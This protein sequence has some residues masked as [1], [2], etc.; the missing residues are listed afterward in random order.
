MVPDDRNKEAASCCSAVPDSSLLPL[1][2][3]SANNKVGAFLAF[4][5]KAVCFTLF[6]EEHF[7]ERELC[8]LAPIAI[9]QFVV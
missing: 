8:V 1:G 4:S 2:R 6:L 3:N 7:P 9:F 5:S